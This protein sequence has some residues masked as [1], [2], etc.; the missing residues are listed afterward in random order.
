MHL[1]IFCIIFVAV[2][3]Q[4]ASTPAREG[5]PLHIDFLSKLFTQAIKAVPHPG[6]TGAGPLFCNPAIA[7]G[8]GV[9]RPGRAAP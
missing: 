5:T 7:G 4:V 3:Q 6:I 2:K 9:S 1:P 8:R